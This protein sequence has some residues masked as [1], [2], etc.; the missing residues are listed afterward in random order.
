MRY[1]CIKSLFQDPEEEK[2]KEKEWVASLE[3][4]E[5]KL[6]Y[7][8]KKRNLLREAF[9]HGSFYSGEEERE[10]Y[11][12]LEYVGDSVLGLM[13]TQELFFLY[14]DSP[15]GVLTKLR[16][17]NVDNE[18]LA[19]AAINH[20]FHRYLRH[21]AP[22]LE[23]QIREFKNETLKYPVHSQGLVD[24]PKSL[25]DIIEAVIGAVYLDVDCKV[26]EVWK[27]F[28]K[29]LE[30]IINPETLKVHPVTELHE[31]CQ[32][33]RIKIEFVKKKREEGGTTYDVVQDSDL[34]IGTATCACKKEVVKNR[35]AKKALDYLKATL[36]L[37]E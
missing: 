17:A 35:A 6:G 8:F 5:E 33:N 18:K 11:E 27:V 31:L 13:I 28:N 36:A 7:K 3:E 22:D 12:R 16:A 30:P 19:R 20:G 15:P 10:T 29:L 9:I 21:K 32:K 1:P 26:D 37:G 14:P 34:I 24:T 4:V 23:D 25:A 2:Q